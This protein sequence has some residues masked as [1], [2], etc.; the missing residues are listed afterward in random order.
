MTPTVLDEVNRLMQQIIAW[1]LPETGKYY[2]AE[3]QHPMSY[4]MCYGSNGAREYIRNLAQDA[5]SLLITAEVTETPDKNKFENNDQNLITYISDIISTNPPNPE[6]STN[7]FMEYLADCVRQNAFLLA[8]MEK[9]AC[10]GNGDKYGNSTG[11]CIA[12]DAIKKCN[13]EGK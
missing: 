7:L 6:K 5:L 13:V 10:L 11:N 2:D 3:Q 8:E 12:I 9:L 1:K 4:E